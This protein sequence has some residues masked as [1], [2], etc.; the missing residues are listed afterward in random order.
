MAKTLGERVRQLR[1]A[2]SYSQRE[3]AK[4]V[5]TSA[6]LISFIERDRNRPNYEIVRRL[7]MVFETTTDYLISGTSANNAPD[8]ELVQ[9]LKN[10]V[11]E[12]WERFPEKRK[13]IVSQL[14]KKINKLSD[15][16]KYVLARVI[17]KLEEQKK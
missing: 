15:T 12:K 17:E 16:D 4:L 9:R 8:E 1:H 14:D 2:H 7:A 10:E 5:G 6:G 13:K 3:L 11:T